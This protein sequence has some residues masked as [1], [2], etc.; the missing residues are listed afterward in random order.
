[1]CTLSQDCYTISNDN[2]FKT[3]TSCNDAI[4]N[5]ITSD[6]FEPMYMRFEEDVMYYVVDTKCVNWF[7]QV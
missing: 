2:L 6:Y 3:E 1:M 7:T 4:Y 5:F